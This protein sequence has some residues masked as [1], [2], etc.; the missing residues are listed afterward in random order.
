MKEPKKA[1]VTI[2]SQNQLDNITKKRRLK[3]LMEKQGILYG[4][5]VLDTTVPD[6]KVEAGALKLRRKSPIEVLKESE[7]LFQTYIC[8]QEGAEDI[9]QSTRKSSN[10]FDKL[11]IE[12]DS[13]WKNAFDMLM[14]FA[15][16]YNVFT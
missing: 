16:C 10:M 9:T 13:S 5:N 6:E 2:P 11:V 8:Q 15:S 4:I 12:K 14:L 3:K 7:D 1:P